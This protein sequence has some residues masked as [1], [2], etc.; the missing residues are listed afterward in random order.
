MLWLSGVQPST[1]LRYSLLCYR[2][3]LEQTSRN[4]LQTIEVINWPSRL[5]P[6]EVNKGRRVT[7]VP[8]WN[9]HEFTQNLPHQRDLTMVNEL[10]YLIVSQWLE[11]YTYK[12]LAQS[13]QNGIILLQCLAQGD[14]L[15]SLDRV[16][17]MKIKYVL[18]AKDKSVAITQVAMMD[19]KESYRE[20]SSWSHLLKNN[21]KEINI[22]SLIISC[23]VIDHAKWQNRSSIF[24]LDQHH[25]SQCIIWSEEIGEVNSSFK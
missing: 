18:L 25:V 22:V 21:S 5:C 9:I 17:I 14:K 10:S 11:Q 2:G 24:I 7:E 4:G 20:E 23:E 1:S 16:S 12:A 8:S 6:T 15:K 19:Q 3:S 13:H